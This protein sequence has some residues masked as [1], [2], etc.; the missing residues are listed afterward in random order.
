[1]I[2]TNKL[3]ISMAFCGCECMIHNQ[4]TKKKNKFVEYTNIASP[5]SRE[6]YYDYDDFY[7]H[8]IQEERTVSMMM[9]MTMTMTMMMMRMMMM[10]MMV[11]V[12]VMIMMVMVMMMM[13]IIDD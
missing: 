10:M 6:R 13:I 7:L 3:W 9:T 8:Y 1:M 2:C 11:M 4:I 5:Y 12:M